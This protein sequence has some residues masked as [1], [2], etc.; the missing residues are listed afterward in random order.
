M[1]TIKIF[2]SHLPYWRNSAKSAAHIPTKVG[3]TTADDDGAGV[4]GAGVELPG[5]LVGACVV[6][7]SGFFVG[8]C[9]GVSVSSP[10]SMKAPFPRIVPF[11]ASASELI[12]L[13]IS[14][15]VPTSFSSFAGCST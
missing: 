1:Q 5:F 8:A 9:V 11:F 4:P 6:E 2:Y 10:L 13:T 3:T 7:L 15:G 12:S 14:L